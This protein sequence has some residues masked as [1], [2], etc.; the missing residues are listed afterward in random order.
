MGLALCTGIRHCHVETGKS[1]SV[2]TQLVAHQTKNIQRHM[3]K[4]VHKLLYIK[5][6]TDDK[7]TDY[8]LNDTF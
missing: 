1:Q 3:D 5:D 8:L 2:G 6:Y 7:R 4:D